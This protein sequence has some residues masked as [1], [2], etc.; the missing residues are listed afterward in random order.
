ML[1]SIAVTQR[2]HA[3]GH[4]GAVMRGKEL[5]LEKYLSRA[6]F[7]E[8]LRVEDCCLISDG[9]GAYVMTSADRAKDFPHRPA[10][11]Q[12]VGHGVSNTRTYF[13]QQGDFTST[14]QVFSA[15]P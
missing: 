6:P 1:G 3:N 14:P 8:P 13:A 10:I 15:P 4:P 7:I 12:G 5:T 9:A 11:V 2:R